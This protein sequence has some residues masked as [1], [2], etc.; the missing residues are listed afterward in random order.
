MDL[1]DLFERGTAWTASKVRGAADQ[2]DT[3]TPCD[4]W[5]VRRLI[6]H[7]LAGQAMFA[8]APTGGAVAPPIG[9][10]PELI[11]DDPVQQYEDARKA[12]AHA[13]GQPG[14][15]EGTLS[16]AG[17]M[18]AAQLLG[19]AFCDQLIHGWDLA[20]ATGQDTTMPDDLAA[21]AWGVLDGQI[22]DGARGPGGIFKAAVPVADDARVQDKL[23]AYCGRDPNQ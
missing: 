14:V 22:S 2:L 10:P 4:E 21:A 15:I 12:T 13:F 20:K 8:A 11:G 19:I 7:M 5:T 23:I 18:P 9:Q 1:L 6:D 16:G 17:D 3:Q